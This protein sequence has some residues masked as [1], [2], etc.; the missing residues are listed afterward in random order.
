MVSVSAGVL[1]TMVEWWDE[2]MCWD[3]GLERCCGAGGRRR[4]RKKEAESDLGCRRSVENRVCLKQ[5]G[6]EL[7]VA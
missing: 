4:E 2:V 1:L 5:S 3:L 6:R 7:V